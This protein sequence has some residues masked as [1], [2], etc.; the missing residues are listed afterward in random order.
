[1]GMLEKITGG[2]PTKP[3]EAVAE[4]IGRIEENVLTPGEHVCDAAEYRAIA[5]FVRRFCER[6]KLTETFGNI[7]SGSK[8]LDDI[9]GAYAW[10]QAHVE[11][12][13]KVQVDLE[14][15]KAEADIEDLLSQYESSL[16][17]ESFG[18]AKLNEE[19]KRKAHAHLQKIRTIIDE[20]GVSD[21]KKNALFERINALARE[22]DAHGTRTDRFFAFAGDV[23]F[24]LGD[25]TKKAKPLL[26]EVKEV[27][28]IVSRSR[29]RQEG[30]SLPPGDEVLQLAPPESEFE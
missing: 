13:R 3:S 24:V 7:S 16:P 10:L 15:S 30:V 25:V 11:R 2:L 5:K 6:F 27:L 1:M 29:A 20:S 12:L 19:E 28:R 17:G 8:E 23:G 9:D 21:R 14:D 22:V 4:L 26:H 18:L